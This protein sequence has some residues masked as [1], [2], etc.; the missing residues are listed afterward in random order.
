MFRFKL[1]QWWPSVFKCPKFGESWPA[2]WNFNNESGIEND[3][4]E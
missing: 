4:F 3:I 1:W 2:Y